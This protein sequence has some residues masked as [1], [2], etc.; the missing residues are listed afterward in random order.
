MSMKSWSKYLGLTVIGPLA[1]S[2]TASAQAPSISMSVWTAPGLSFNDCM[3]K[4]ADAMRREGG[5]MSQQNTSF[6]G[7]GFINGSLGDYS[8][9][10]NC[11]TFKGTVTFIVA[12]SD[13]PTADSHRRQLNTNMGNPPPAPPSPPAVSPSPPATGGTSCQRFPNLC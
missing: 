8:L 10:I 7:M 2:A 11:M 13:G 6:P 4:G 1:L 9:I 12:G 3:Q 5:T